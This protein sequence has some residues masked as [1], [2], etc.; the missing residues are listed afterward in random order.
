MTRVYVY[1]Y[2]HTYLFA[3]KCYTLIHSKWIALAVLTF[4]HIVTISV[5]ELTI[6][7]Y[8]NHYILYIYIYRGEWLKFDNDWDD[9]IY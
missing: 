8:Y 5:Y 1:K 3:G 2:T 6:L 7:D 4:L 9:S